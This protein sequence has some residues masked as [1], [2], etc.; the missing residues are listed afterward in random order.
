MRRLTNDEFRE[1]QDKLSALGHDPGPVDGFFGPQTIAAVKRY[2]IAKGQEP[3]GSIDLR[4]LDR[5][6][7]EP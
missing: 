2:E 1:I 4:L 6:R 7:R 5:L 3:T